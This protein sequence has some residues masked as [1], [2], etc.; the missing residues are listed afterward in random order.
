MFDAAGQVGVGEISERVDVDVAG[1]D[2]PEISACVVVQ[3]SRGG[4]PDRFVVPANKIL[5]H[6][7]C[8]LPAFADAGAVAQEEACAFPRRVQGIL[9]QYM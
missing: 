1:P 2:I 3:V 9:G 7:A 5:K 6:Q 8:N 4:E